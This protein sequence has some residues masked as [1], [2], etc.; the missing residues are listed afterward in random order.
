MRQHFLGPCLN[1]GTS[2]IFVLNCLYVTVDSCNRKIHTLMP[3]NQLITCEGSL[4]CV[5]RACLG[6]NSTEKR[7]KAQ[8]P[9]CQGV[10]FIQEQKLK[11]SL[12]QSIN[13]TM[14]LKALFPSF[15]T[16]TIESM[17]SRDIHKQSIKM[18]ILNWVV[19]L[20]KSE[21]LHATQID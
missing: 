8:S 5:K 1:N 11:Y 21:P 17:K 15:P 7:I 6:N 12:E 20:T 19:W 9:T 18:W 2:C 13:F 10:Q 3:G 16:W 4:T 14:T